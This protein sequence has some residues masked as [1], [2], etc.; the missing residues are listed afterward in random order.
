MALLRLQ[1]AA[2]LFYPLLSGVAA[3]FAELLYKG[4]GHDFCAESNGVVS[5]AESS[6]KDECNARCATFS[7]CQY[8]SLWTTGGVNWCHLTKACDQLSQEPEHNITIYR[9]APSNLLE[10]ITKYSK[11]F[12]APN[13]KEVLHDMDLV[14]PQLPLGEEQL[15][16]RV[17]A[18][19]KGGAMLK[20]QALPSALSAETIRK[21]PLQVGTPVKSEKPLRG[22]M[23]GSQ[24]T[25]H[26]E[27]K[28][29][30]EVVSDPDAEE[31]A[32]KYV[33]SSPEDASSQLKAEDS[34]Q[35]VLQEHDAGFLKA[36]RDRRIKTAGDDKGNIP[37]LGP[38]LAGN[39]REPQQIM[40]EE[41]TASMDSGGSPLD[42]ATR[43]KKGPDYVVRPQGPN[44]EVYQNIQQ[45][46]EKYLDSMNNYNMSPKYSVDQTVAMPPNVLNAAVRKEPN[47]IEN[48]EPK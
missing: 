25:D 22:H 41:N 15:F 7:S 26:Q 13:N 14:P 21:H 30:R 39:G 27:H 16:K 28:H 18:A 4:P 48:K 35:G 23:R 44:M 6:G 11:R 8:W 31:L 45:N 12:A 36:L 40:R 46:A 43:N 1:A 2:L 20:D 5:K 3:G 24:V 17:E 42:L 38:F 10:E 29:L 33:D 37:D 19:R 34:K 9:K 32:W 47:W